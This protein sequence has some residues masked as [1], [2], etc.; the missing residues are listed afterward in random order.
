VALSPFLLFSICRCVQVGVC[1]CIYMCVS[2]SSL[3]YDDVVF[4]AARLY[5]LFTCSQYAG[6]C[7]CVCTR[8]IEPETK[9]ACVCGVCVCVW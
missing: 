2:V 8:G 7:V 9:R 5:R 6:M 4:R 3:S 1:V